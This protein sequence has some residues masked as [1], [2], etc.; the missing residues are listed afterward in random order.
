MNQVVDT[1]DPELKRLLNGLGTVELTA[2][3]LQDPR[4]GAPA[5]DHIHDEESGMTIAELAAIHE[6]GLGDVPERSFLRAWFD[7]NETRIEALVQNAVRK[8]MRH[9]GSLEAELD[10][11]AL[12]LQADIQAR[13]V[14]GIPPELEESTKRAKKARSSGPK[15]TPLIDSGVLKSAI[16]AIAK[17]VAA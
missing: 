6:F 17:R 5:G 8:A 10:R 15:E 1:K 9:N 12:V 14:A 4:A 11:V 7:E 16:S 3:I 13:I 2:G